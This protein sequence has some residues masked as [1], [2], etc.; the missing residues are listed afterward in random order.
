MVDFLILVAAGAGVVLLLAVL[1]LAPL[2][3]WRRGPDGHRTYPSPDGL[4][5]PMP[6]EPRAVN[7]D[8]RTDS[9]TRTQWGDD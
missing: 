1:L 7:P 5:P 9:R 3:L 4:L 2:A 6:R 8:S